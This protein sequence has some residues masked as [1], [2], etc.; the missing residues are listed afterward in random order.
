MAPKRGGVMTIASAVEAMGPER[1][2]FAAQSFLARFDIDVNLNFLQ[3]VWEV[4]W[5]TLAGTVSGYAV[6]HRN[7]RSVGMSASTKRR[8]V[9]YPEI[10]GFAAGVTVLGS[11]LSFLLVFRLSWAFSRWW[12]ARGMWGEMLTHLRRICMLLLSTGYAGDFVLEGV[13][14]AQ[15]FVFAVVDELSRGGTTVD[16]LRDKLS[17]EVLEVLGDDRLEMFVGMGTERVA[18]AH[19]WICKSVNVAYDSGL[20]RPAEHIEAHRHI[21]DLLMPFYGMQKV[22]TTPTPD[23][24]IIL[25]R[26]LKISYVILIYPQFMAYAFVMKLSDD[27]VQIKALRRSGFYTCFYVVL[28]ALGII[29][30]CVLHVIA[31]QLD[32]PF[33]NDETDFPLDDWGLAFAKEIQRHTETAFGAQVHSEYL[34]HARGIDAIIPQPAAT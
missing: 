28:V 24:I 30:F 33:G 16:D 12:E 9:G 18:V 32:D 13:A 31:R 26:I 19:S 20:L 5:Y 11:A 21:G 3:C 29:Y 17:P 2:S 10:G 14:C 7:A 25:V 1:V 34:A 22:K 15:I 27:Q 6:F 8:E 23:A 4:L